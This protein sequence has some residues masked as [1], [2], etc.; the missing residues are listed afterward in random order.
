MI[1]HGDGDNILMY[2]EGTEGARERN[3]APGTQW[4]TGGGAGGGNIW[5]LVSQGENPFQ[6]VAK[7]L[8][9]DDGKTM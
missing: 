8:D 4:S 2:W 3:S 6:K 1:N 7:N 9:I 5:R